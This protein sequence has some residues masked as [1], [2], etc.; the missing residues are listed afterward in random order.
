LCRAQAPA[1]SRPPTHATNAADFRDDIASDIVGRYELIALP[2]GIRAE[3]DRGGPQGAVRV[4]GAEEAA[5]LQLGNDT[6][7]EVF[8]R[9]GQVEKDHVEAVGGFFLETGLH[10]I[11]DLVGR[12]DDRAGLVGDLLGQ[13]ADGQ[14]VPASQLVNAVLGALALVG[15]R[16]LGEGAVE[17]EARQV[18]SP[19]PVGEVRKGD[20]RVE[21]RS[22]SR[23]SFSIAL[24]SVS[25]T[26]ADSPG[27]ILSE[28]G[29]RPLLRVR[30]LSSL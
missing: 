25:P 10:V 13:L 2:T 3:E 5:A 23:S 14:V 20:R 28:S 18:E 27:R 29:S 22:R 4:S 19:K 30:S 24:A 6:C 9:A 21:R 15:E 12:T 1:E 8:Q 11:G 26:I 17:R 7:G 16:Q